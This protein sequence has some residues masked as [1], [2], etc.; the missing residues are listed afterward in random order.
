MKIYA[1]A[2]VS[3]L[4]QCVQRQI[5]CFIE[6]G[7]EIKNIFIDKQSGKDFDRTNYKKLLKKLK[8]D[9]ILFIKSIDRLGRNYTKIIEEWNRLSNIIKCKIV[10]IDMPLL[11]TRTT[12][13][14]LIG[15]FIS[16]I[17]LQLL[18]FVAENERAN[19]RERQKEGIIAAQKRGV[20]FGRPNRFY[21]E[22]FIKVVNDYKDRKINLRT[23]LKLLRISKSNFFYHLRK[24]KK[25]YV[26]M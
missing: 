21:T 8:E 5:D 9:D 1:Y 11:D 15:K 10:V 6:K 26:T 25:L 20:K 23:A 4:E 12:N 3:T 17:V 2:R 22:Y 18:S 7:V 19:L 14:S 24:L 13:N 16:D